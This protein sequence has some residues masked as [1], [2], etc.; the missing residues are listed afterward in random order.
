MSL[1]VCFIGSYIFFISFIGG[2]K[3]NQFIT[4]F[5]KKARGTRK[6][7]MYNIYYTHTHKCNMMNLDK[8]YKYPY[9]KYIYLVKN[10]Q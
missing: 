4:K 6:G 8:N 9:M 3:F 2:H 5:K 1:C 7:T 10:K